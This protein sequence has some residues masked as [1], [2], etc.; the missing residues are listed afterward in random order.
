MIGYRRSVREIELSRVADKLK[1]ISVGYVYLAEMP[2]SP[3]LLNIGRTTTDPQNHIAQMLTEDPQG[4]KLVHA[5]AVPNPKEVE[6]QLHRQ[7]SATR[8]K[9]EWFQVSV[10]EAKRAIY[11]LEERVASKDAQR[12]LDRFILELGGAT[13]GLRAYILIMLSLFLGIGA[14]VAVAAFLSYVWSLFIDDAIGR[15]ILLLSGMMIGFP[16]GLSLVG[17]IGAAFKRTIFAREKANKTRRI[18]QELW[19]EGVFIVG[20]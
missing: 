5:F 7:F 17:T 15:S 1:N 2:G 19:C 3:G 16:A 6:H 4:L 8:T 18:K 20:D 13:L 14:G 9:D 11:A 12:E 10:T